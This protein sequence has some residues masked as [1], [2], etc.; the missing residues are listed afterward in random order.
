VPYERTIG[1]LLGVGLLI[2]AFLAPFSDIVR[3]P[4]SAPESLFGSLYFSLSNVGAMQTTG[5][6]QMAELDYI[7]IAAAVIV[8]VAGLAGAFA[9]LSGALGIAGLVLATLAPFAALNGYSFS[10]ADYGSG[11][12]TLWVLS[13]VLVFY[14]VWGKQYAGTIVKLGR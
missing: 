7:Y 10:L 8:I 14:G 2:L 6:T 12:F 13:A 1:G 4:G 9:V 3:G 11:F 5:N